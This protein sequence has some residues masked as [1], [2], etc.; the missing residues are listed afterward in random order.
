MMDAWSDWAGQKARLE[1][2]T[3]HDRP[4]DCPSFNSYSLK[5]ERGCCTAWTALSNRRGVVA[6]EISN[7][8]TT[9]LTL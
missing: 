8:G 3:H 1:V 2:P 4:S 7:H 6:F 9:I 5:Y